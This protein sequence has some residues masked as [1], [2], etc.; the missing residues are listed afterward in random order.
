MIALLKNGDI[1]GLEKV[2]P[3]KD[4]WLY[5]KLLDYKKVLSEEN[6]SIFYG[7]FIKPAT[8]KGNYGVNF[9]AFGK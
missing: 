3:P 5:S 7:G 8:I 9:F 6:D 1:K 2:T 4:T